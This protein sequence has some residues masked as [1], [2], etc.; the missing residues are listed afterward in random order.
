[1]ISGKLLYS[2][3]F[4]ISLLSYYMTHYTK[5]FPFSLTKC[6]IIL[7]PH[8]T[9]FSNKG[10]PLLKKKT[11][12][13]IHKPSYIRLNHKSP[14]VL[15]YSTWCLELQ[16]D[17]SLKLGKFIEAIGCRIYRHTLFM[18]VITWFTI[19]DR[20][21]GR[22]SKHL[23]LIISVPINMA[24]GRAT[25]FWILQNF[26]TN[27]KGTSAKRLINILTTKPKVFKNPRLMAEEQI[28]HRM[29][30]KAWMGMI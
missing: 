15:L 19:I 5:I 29:L 7:T 25:T 12:R 24:I 3:C 9:F 16:S 11:K 1:M 27:N 17:E 23:N 2:K 18:A 26:S 22:Y 30:R 10:C 4:F 6:Q 21:R 20:I 13:V 14:L 28:N 8:G